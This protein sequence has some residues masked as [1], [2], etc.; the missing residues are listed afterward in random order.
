M[1]KMVL[2]HLVVRQCNSLMPTHYY[3]MCGGLFVLPVSEPEVVSLYADLKEGLM[4]LGNIMLKMFLKVGCS[5]YAVLRCMGVKSHAAVKEFLRGIKC[6]S[7]VE[8]RN[9]N[10]LVSFVH[11][12]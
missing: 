11:P 7:K 8:N 9:D 12:K 6:K 5:A 2:I 4:Q 3:Y 1:S 10:C